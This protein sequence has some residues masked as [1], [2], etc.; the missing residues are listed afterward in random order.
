MEIPET[1][2]LRDRFRHYVLRR[3]RGVMTEV[4]NQIGCKRQHLS[5]FLHQGGNLGP[6]KLIRLNAILDGRPLDERR[7]VGVFRDHANANGTPCPLAFGGR[8]TEDAPNYSPASASFPNF[9]N[10][11]TAKATLFDAGI[12]ARTAGMPDVQDKLDAIGAQII[13]AH[14]QWNTI[15]TSFQHLLRQILD[16]HAARPRPPVPRKPHHEEAQTEPKL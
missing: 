7:Y 9:P 10:L 12:L 15:Q 2:E 13:G 3:G 16:A 6:D 11:D 5:R 8:V 1:D 4:A 14:K